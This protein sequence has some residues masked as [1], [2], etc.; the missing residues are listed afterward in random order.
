MLKV[1][2]N[3]FQLQLQHLIKNPL[4]DNEFECIEE[5]FLCVAPVADTLC[6]FQGD[7]AIYEILLPCLFTEL[8]KI[9]H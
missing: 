8:K 1:K 9:T 6:I 5:H 4:R 7:N 2:A 3:N